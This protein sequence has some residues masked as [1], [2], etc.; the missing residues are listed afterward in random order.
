M[1][2]RNLP[3]EWQGRLLELGYE[4]RGKASASR[5]AAAADV[6]PTAALRVI[7]RDGESDAD[8]LRRIGEAMRDSRWVA[9]WVGIDDIGQ[10]EPPAEYRFLDEDQRDVIDR[11]IRLF[12][13]DKIGGLG[14]GKHREKIGG[15]AEEGTDDGWARRQPRKM[16]GPGPVETRSRR[17]Q[18]HE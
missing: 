13:R 6:S 14:H 2:Q 16:G 8:T 4:Y 12:A 9:Q 11:T 7:F 10:R 18:S 15:G 1:A 5:L 3:S 17:D